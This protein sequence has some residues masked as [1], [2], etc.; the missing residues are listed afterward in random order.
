MNESTDHWCDGISRKITE[1]YLRLNCEVITIGRSL[2]NDIVA[3]LEEVNVE[4]LVTQVR[5]V[6]TIVHCAAIN[7]VLINDSIDRTYNINVTLTRKLT[8]LASLADIRSFIYISTFHVYG[9]SSGLVTDKS[10]I[11]PI[12]DYG[13]THYLSEEII[14]TRSKQAEFNY[15]IIRPTNIYGAPSSFDTFDRWTLVPFQ[16]CVMR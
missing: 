9:I 5:D 11:N 16:F 12:N 15:L 10:E 2:Q 7:E 4:E 3:D 14:R 1:H 6:D 13:L 8:E